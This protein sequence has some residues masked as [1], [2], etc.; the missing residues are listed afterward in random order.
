MNHQPFMELNPYL[1]QPIV[2]RALEEDL[3]TGDVTT[4]LLVPADVKCRA[5]LVAKERGIIAGLDVARLTFESLDNEVWWEEAVSDGTPVE[6]GTTLAEV[7]GPARAILSG[8]RV[9]LNF[10]QHLSGIATM[11]HRLVQAVQPHRAKIVDTRKTTPGLR[12]LEK[13]AV[14][15]GGGHNHRFGLYDAV[16]IKDNHLALT[17]GVRAAVEQARRAL[18]HTMKI[19]VEVKNLDE[20]GEALEA[21]ADIILLD[22]MTP[23][24]MS[25]AVR[26]ANGRA[27]LEA[28]G[29]IDERNVAEVAATGVDLISI[30]ALTHS[31]KALDISLE[32]VEVF[33]I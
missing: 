28:S 33:T 27:L 19:E 21:H 17:D 18:P 13:Y 29:G 25:A 3:G 26:L 5:E 30:G 20:L 32:V 10:L 12:L 11:T 2:D 8:E 31:V 4:E 1:I 23:D 15:V 16:L 14:R 7:G 6:P 22:N 24:E 9:A